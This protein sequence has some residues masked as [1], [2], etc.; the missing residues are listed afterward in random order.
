MKK[1]IYTKD[2]ESLITKGESICYICSNTIITPAAQDLARLNNISFK[3]QTCQETQEVTNEQ[4]CTEDMVSKGDLISKADLLSLL[5]SLLAGDVD[6]DKPYIAKTNAKGIKAIKGDSVRMDVF[7]TGTPGADVKFQELV[8]QEESK[9]SAGFL[10]INKSAF[11]WNLT[12]EE[13]DYVI[14][15]TLEVTYNGETFTANAGD[16]LFVPKDTKVTWSSPNKAKVFYTTYPAN[17]PDL[18]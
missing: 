4:V 5:K 8:S 9:V 1:L 10:E 14:D 2:I 16:V 6:L 3:E 11:E 18:L 7:D 12:Y 17:W 13:I 15:G